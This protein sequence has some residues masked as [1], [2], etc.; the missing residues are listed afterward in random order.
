MKRLK[1]S[2]DYIMIVVALTVIAIMAALILSAVNIFT[3]VSEAELIKRALSNN[4]LKIEKEYSLNTFSRYPDTELIFAGKTPDNKYVIISKA[5]KTSLNCYGTEGIAITVVI[6]DDIIE[7][8]VSYKHAE[9]P[10][11]GSKALNEKHLSQ[12]Y[13]KNVNSFNV[14]E[15]NKIAHE[16]EPSDFVPTVVTSATYSTNGVN[17]AVKNAI[18]AYLAIIKGVNSESK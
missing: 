16:G 2:K 11:L 1:I 10:G 14:G 5:N 9:T 6:K 7:K 12:Y 18:K 15:E 3:H 17:V 13:G 4:D 8:I